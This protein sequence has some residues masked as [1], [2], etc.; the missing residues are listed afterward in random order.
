MRLSLIMYGLLVF[1]GVVL[2]YGLLFADIRANYPDTQ[3]S[4]ASLGAFDTF[5]QTMNVTNSMTESFRGA[6]A[7]Q[8]ADTV[9]FY[10]SAG[11]STARLTS[12]AAPIAGGLITASGN[13]LGIPDYWQLIALQ[14][15][16]LSLVIGIIAVVVR[17]YL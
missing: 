8:G 15:F 4:E 14:L 17:W 1:A 7:A 6:K 2:S 11:V 3:V 5:N 9:G 16:V 10:L 12:Q 13:L